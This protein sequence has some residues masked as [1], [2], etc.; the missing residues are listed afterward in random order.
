M[1][2]GSSGLTLA[3]DAHSHLPV[4]EQAQAPDLD[5][6]RRRPAER[7]LLARKV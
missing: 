3:L 2:G 5:P 6:T 4:A 7:Q 1:P